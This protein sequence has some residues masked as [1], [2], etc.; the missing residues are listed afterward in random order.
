[1]VKKIPVVVIKELSEVDKILP[2]L[3]NDGIDYAEITF[4]TAC[5]EEAIRYAAKKY[6]DMIIGAGTV[7]NAEQCL[8]KHNS[9]YKMLSKCCQKTTQ[10]RTKKN[11]HTAAPRLGAKPLEF[12]GL[13][14]S[15]CAFYFPSP[16]R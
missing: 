6:P 12:G 10:N 7:I 5:A 11:T 2:A 15:V 9:A 16:D 3:R 14:A 8:K 1:M 4:R 13:S